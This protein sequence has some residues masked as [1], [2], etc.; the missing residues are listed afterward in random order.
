MSSFAY[1]WIDIYI[2]I[3]VQIIKKLILHTKKQLISI[4]RNYVTRLKPREKEWNLLTHIW[5]GGQIGAHWW[6]ASPPV[7][8]WYKYPDGYGH[9][10]KDLLTCSLVGQGWGCP[11]APNSKITK[12]IDRNGQMR[13]CTCVTW[14]A[15]GHRTIILLS[16]YDV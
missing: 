10:G 2:W 12:R 3:S 8:F 6:W 11:T 16:L 9:P 4:L 7:W 14:K 5:S 15:C 1:I 13:W